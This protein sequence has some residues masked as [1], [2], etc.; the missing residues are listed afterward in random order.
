ML[1]LG[2]LSKSLLLW[3]GKNTFQRAACAR[4]SPAVGALPTWCCHAT[5]EGKGITCA[6]LV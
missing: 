5:S 6:V 1:Y 2:I 3:L 4:K